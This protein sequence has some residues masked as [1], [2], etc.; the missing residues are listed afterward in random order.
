V[1]AFN[2]D[3]QYIVGFDRAKLE[4]LVLGKVVECPK[5]RA[6]HRVPRG[7]GRIRITCS[8][9]GTKFDVMT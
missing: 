1:P 4:G 2:I 3:G 6:Q 8:Q 7:K 9:C 5:C